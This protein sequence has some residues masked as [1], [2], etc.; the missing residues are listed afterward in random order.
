MSPFD[1]QLWFLEAIRY[2]RAFGFFEDYHISDDE[3]GEAIKLYWQGDWNDFLAGVSESPSADQLL[4]IADTQRVWWHDLEGVYR[5]ADYYISALNDWAAISRGQFRPTQIEEGWRSDN[6]PVE[7]TF[8]MNGKRYTFVHRSGDFLD[9]GILKLINQ[10]LARTPFRYEVAN[11]YG[12]SNW[13]VVLE[14]DEKKRLMVERG[15][16]FLW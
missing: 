6:S 11:D 13:I 15:W 14:Q 7:V 12:D 16:H 2:F 8:A 10:A 5:G 4:L 1:S 3:L 9:H